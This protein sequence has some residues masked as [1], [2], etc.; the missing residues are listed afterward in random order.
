MT[1][2]KMTEPQEAKSL[3]AS[4][5]HAKSR[6]EVRLEPRDKRGK[7]LLKE[8]GPVWDLLWSNKDCIAFNGPGLFIRSRV[9]ENECRW[10]KPNGEPHFRRKK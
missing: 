3:R 10:I 1:T 6:N 4:G 7:Q 9:D 5:T 2:K 8:H